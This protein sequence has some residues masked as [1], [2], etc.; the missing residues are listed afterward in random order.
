MEAIVSHFLV[1]TQIDELFT[2]SVYFQLHDTSNNVI[3]QIT[4]DAPRGGHN[5]STVL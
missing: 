2:T 3:L 4:D 1:P 5:Q